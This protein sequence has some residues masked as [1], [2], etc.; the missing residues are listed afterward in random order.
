MKI[1]LLIGLTFGLLIQAKAG[2]I[3]SQWRGPNRDGVYPA[4]NLIKNWPSNGPKLI[5]S[6]EGLGEGYSSPAVTTDGIYITGM[7]DASGYLVALD[8]NG[9]R[10][11][12]I[13]YGPEWDGGH[14]GARTTPTIVGDKI[15][16]MSGEGNVVCVSVQKGEILWSVD[17]IKAF[18]ARNLHWGMTESL[19]V[20]GDR[21]FCT[22]GGRNVMMAILDRHSGKTIKKIKGNGEESSYCSP[23]LIKHNGKRLILTMTAKSVVGIDAESG[24]YLWRH[25]HIT[26]YDIN[27]NTPIY[28]DGYIL[29]LSGYGTGAQLLKLAKDGKSVKQVWADKTMD[30]QMGAA[31]IVDGYIYGSGHQNKGWHCVNWKTGKVKYSARELGNKGNIIFADGM[32]YCYAENGDVG[33]IKPSP[34]KFDIKGK[35]EIKEGSGPHWAHP[36]IARGSLYI[37]HGEVLRVYDI[38]KK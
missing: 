24:E 35:F 5:W 32:L 1:L 6:A 26:R 10:R 21:I 20:D 23:L 12:R 38:S 33:L 28:K 25:E 18:G 9:N 30:S 4:K 7:V 14:E 2:E 16:L 19:L 27:P 3:L 36:V 13:N 31:V 11:W 15:Y 29:I 22:P 34:E 8:K 37:R 17:L